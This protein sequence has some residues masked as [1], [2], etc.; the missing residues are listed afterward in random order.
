MGSCL[1]KL[2]RVGSDLG[3]NIFRSV[4]NSKMLVRR[5]LPL[6][7]FACLASPFINFKRGVLNLLGGSKAQKKPANQAPKPS[8]GAPPQTYNAPAP[9]Y[10]APVSSYNPPAP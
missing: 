1:L 3:S 5:I 9:S 10:S 7:V 6:L 8:Y 4:S 2:G